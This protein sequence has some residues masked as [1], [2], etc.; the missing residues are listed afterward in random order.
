[1]VTVAAITSTI[2]KRAYPQ[3]VYL[4]GRPAGPLPEEGTILCGQLMTVAKDRL[5]SYRGAL[6]PAQVQQVNAAL[7]AHFGL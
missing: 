1:V 5:E 3:N 2:P 4:P 6:T 7:R